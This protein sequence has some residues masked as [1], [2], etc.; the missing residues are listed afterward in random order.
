MPPPPIDPSTAFGVGSIVLKGGRYVFRAD[1]NANFFKALEGRLQ[2]QRGLSR[3]KIAGFAVDPQ[4]QHEQ[5]P[6]CRATSPL[7]TC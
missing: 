5:S 6:R 4:F 1:E 3:E 2:H 7:A